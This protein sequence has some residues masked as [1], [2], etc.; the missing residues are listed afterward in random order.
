MFEYLVFYEYQSYAWS[1]EIR[2]EVDGD[3][4]RYVIKHMESGLPTGVALKEGLYSGDPM[5]FIA[6]LEGCNVDQWKGCSKASSSGHGWTLR[7]KEVG[8]PCLKVKSSDCD[9]ETCIRFIRL[10]SSVCA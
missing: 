7:Y 5:Q 3:K 1:R 10:V 6:D 2:I 9:M 4:L 8:K